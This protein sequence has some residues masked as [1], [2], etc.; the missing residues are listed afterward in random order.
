MNNS[1]WY[2]AEQWISASIEAYDQKSSQTDM[3]LLRGPKLADLCR[4]LGQVQMKQSE[5]E[6]HSTGYLG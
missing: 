2:A 1:R 3:E 5:C 6:V 4:I